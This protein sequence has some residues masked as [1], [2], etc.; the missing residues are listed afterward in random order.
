MGFVSAGGGEDGGRREGDCGGADGDG[1]GDG[2]GGNDCG[3]DG[4]GGGNSASSSSPELEASSSP[5][6]ESGESKLSDGSSLEPPMAI[7]MLFIHSASGSASN[8]AAS[9]IIAKNKNQ[10]VGLSIFFCDAPL[11]LIWLIPVLVRM[12]KHKFEPERLS[13]GHR[14]YL[15]GTHHWS[16]LL[17]V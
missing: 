6:L 15:P 14:P 16:C 10:E 4:D 9:A 2:G 13:Q 7:G 5:E 1:D 8:I 11:N 12:S 3:R 17:F